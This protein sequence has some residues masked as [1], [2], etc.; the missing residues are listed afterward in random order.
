MT[1]PKPQL[2]Q[3]VIVTF[4]H[5]TCDVYSPKAVKTL[6]YGKCYG[7]CFLFCVE[8]IF[9]LVYRSVGP[10]PKIK[11]TKKGITSAL[12]CAD[13]AGFTFVT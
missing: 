12:E 11:Y 5:A 13:V 6:M 1:R 7:Y 8:S 2:G 4:N 10:E 3:I 9:S